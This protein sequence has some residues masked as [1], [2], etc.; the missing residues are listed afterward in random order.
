[1]INRTLFVID[2]KSSSRHGIIGVKVNVEIILTGNKQL[3][4]SEHSRKSQQNWC[5]W[6]V[7]IVYHYEI[8]ARL[9][10]DIFQ[11]K[12]VHWKLNHNRLLQ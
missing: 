6:T 2:R 7:A 5:G 4:A 12:I 3:R 9:Q 11:L 8:F 1:M 10:H